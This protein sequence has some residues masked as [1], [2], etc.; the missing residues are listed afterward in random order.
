MLIWKITAI[1]LIINH[2]HEQNKIRLSNMLIEISQVMLWGKL[3][4]DK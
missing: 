3:T 2:I 4:C 1:L